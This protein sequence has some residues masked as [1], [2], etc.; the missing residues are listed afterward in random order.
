MKSQLNA[1]HYTSKIYNIISKPCYV[2][3]DKPISYKVF[4]NK[5]H[6]VMKS[7]SVATYVI[8]STGIF[9]DNYI[10]SG[11]QRVHNWKFQYFC[12]WKYIA[13]APTVHRHDKFWC[14]YNVHLYSPSWFNTLQFEQHIPQ[15]N[16]TLKITLFSHLMLVYTAKLMV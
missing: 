15:R 3:Y 9:N 14:W 10:H 5:K 13:L 2:I 1:Y 4:F 12:K 11:H 16:I 6:F 8:S 7:W